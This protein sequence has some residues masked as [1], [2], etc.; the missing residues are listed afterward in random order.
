MKPLLWVSPISHPF[1]LCASQPCL[2]T[3]VQNTLSSLRMCVKGNSSLQDLQPL[4][5]QAEKSN[6]PPSSYSLVTPAGRNSPPRHRWALQSRSPHLPV[7][8]LRNPHIPSLLHLHSLLLAHHLG[9]GF[10]PCLTNPPQPSCA[11]CSPRSPT[12]TAQL[13]L[14]WNLSKYTQPANPPCCPLPWPVPSTDHP[15][16][17]ALVKHQAG[18]AR[19]T[20]PTGCWWSRENSESGQ[21]AECW[22]LCGN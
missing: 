14:P 1:P 7:V 4:Q 2:T 10:S 5:S 18:P 22:S 6:S 11:Q 13:L 8:P 16:P 3:N 12:I 17:S 19:G 21:E 15:K 20:A 9:R